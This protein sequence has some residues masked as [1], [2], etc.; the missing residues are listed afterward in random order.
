M[1][2]GVWYLPL[3]TI[4]KSRHH[5]TCKHSKQVKIQTYETREGTHRGTALEGSVVVTPLGSFRCTKP[6]S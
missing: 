3:T 2:E 4:Q 6:H 5:K 1:G